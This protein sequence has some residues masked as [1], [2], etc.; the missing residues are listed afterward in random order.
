MAVRGWTA[1]HTLRTARSPT[2]LSG[3]VAHGG[4]DGAQKVHTWSHIS[5][6]LPGVTWLLLLS[7]DPG[8]G[9]AVCVT[10]ATARGTA[11]APLLLPGLQ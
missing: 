8:D 7:G 6:E 2:L 10:V 5:P 3:A 9:E 11:Q 1:L 4:Q